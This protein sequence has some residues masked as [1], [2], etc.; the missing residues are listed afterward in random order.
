MRKC[1]TC[2]TN[3]ALTE[4]E[5]PKCSDGSLPLDSIVLGDGHAVVHE[6]VAFDAHSQACGAA[7]MAATST[8][9]ELIVEGTNPLLPARV[10]AARESIPG[11]PLTAPPRISVRKPPPHTPVNQIAPAPAEGSKYD[12][13]KVRVQAQ[14]ARRSFQ[15]ATAICTIAALAL[16]CTGLATFSHL[17]KMK[18]AAGRPTI[19]REQ[20][21]PE[22]AQSR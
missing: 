6:R 22:F 13:I 5:C 14:R 21:R 4:N 11:F 7:T 18:T 15:M 3:L 17:R 8:R 20:R 12:E 10:C 1:P 16:I 19:S 9:G 2:S